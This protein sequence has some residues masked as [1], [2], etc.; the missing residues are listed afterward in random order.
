MYVLRKSMIEG[1]SSYVT[2]EHMLQQLLKIRF[3]NCFWNE[4]K[5]EKRLFSHN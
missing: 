4:A 1:Y 2:P 3:K 5:V